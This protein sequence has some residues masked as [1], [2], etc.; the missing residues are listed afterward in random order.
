MAHTAPTP[1]DLKLRYDAF[2]AVDDAKVQYWLTD[3]LRFVDTSWD[4]HDY[5][6]ALMAAAAHHMALRKLGTDVTAQIPAGVTSFKSGDFSASIAESAAARSAAGGWAATE[7][8]LEFK[9]L[10]RRNKGGPRLVGCA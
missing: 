6:P 4:E 2:A 10:L 3:A 9:A 7:Y 1:A 8:G 5:A